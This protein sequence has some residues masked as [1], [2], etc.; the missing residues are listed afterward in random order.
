MSWDDQKKITDFS[1]MK[2]LYYSIGEVS[3]ITAIEPHV[4]RYWE[5]IFE[6]LT[7]RKNKAGNRTYREDDLTFI[8]QLKDLIQKKKYSTAGAKKIVEEDEQEAEGAKTEDLSMHLKKDL[9]E[10][11]LFLNKLLEKL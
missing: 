1:A 3:E 8:L 7:P 11:N 9:R 10:V 2:K 5:T 6:D 4:L